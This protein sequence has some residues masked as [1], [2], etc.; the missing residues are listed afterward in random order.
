MS[1]ACKLAGGSP[2]AGHHLPLERLLPLPRLGQP[3]F[4]A[5]DLAR[6]AR[7]LQGLQGRFRIGPDLQIRG[8]SR[9]QRVRLDADHPGFP[10]Q[11]RGLQIAQAVVHLGA[12]QEYQVRFFEQ[13]RSPGGRAD[14]AD[15][16]IHGFGN[17]A[18]VPDGRYHGHGVRGGEVGQG[19]LGAGVVRAAAG[20]QQRLPRFLQQSDS[21]VEL[22]GSGSP[23]A[24]PHGRRAGRHVFHGRC[25]HIHGKAQMHG[26]WPAVEGSGKGR[27]HELGDAFGLVHQ[28]GV[29]AD[30][31]GQG[32][33]VEVLEV[34]HA[35]GAQGSGPGHQQH[36]GAVEVGVDHAGHGIGVGHAAAHQADAWPAAEPAP[37]FG[38]V[39][40]G[41]L[42][43]G[44]DHP[45]A[46]FFAGGQEFIE[47]VA[48]QSG[49]PLDSLVLQAG[50]EE[51]G[52]VHGSLLSTRRRAVRA[53]T[54]V[55]S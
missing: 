34:S 51:F 3:V 13:P 33:L 53:A 2:G 44:V 54:R 20:H 30:R 17:G 6:N 23:V 4:K 26:S 32:H 27:V 28:A 41:L 1:R 42:V 37:A 18:A 48:A 36:G 49:D 16:L 19:L 45:D 47:A 15:V 12:D 5:V 29:L 9:P 24:G 35:G 46:G 7:L 22:L 43:A 31:R 8:P 11:R 38:H 14:H 21:L 25:L 40:G 55:L 39:R 52:T 10:A 50:D